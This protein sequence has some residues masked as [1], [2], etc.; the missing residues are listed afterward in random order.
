MFWK[1]FSAGRQLRNLNQFALSS[2]LLSLDQ[3]Y[4]LS[5]QM[6]SK[7]FYSLICLKLF[8]IEIKPGLCIITCTLTNCYSKEEKL[9][10]SAYMFCEHVKWIG[11]QFVEQRKNILFIKPLSDKFIKKH[12]LIY[13]SWNWEVWF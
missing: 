7:F 3:I 10:C 5:K 11:K 8:K 4:F 6:T 2:V 13:Q 12:V 9:N 1:I